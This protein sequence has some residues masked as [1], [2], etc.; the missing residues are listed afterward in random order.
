MSGVIWLINPLF[1]SRSG[2]APLLSS[3]APRYHLCY[4]T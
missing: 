3:V 1:F 4:S 2:L